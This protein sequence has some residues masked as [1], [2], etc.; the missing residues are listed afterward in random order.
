MVA[1]AAPAFPV[2]FKGNGADDA[3]ANDAAA[4]VSVSIAD[5]TDSNVTTMALDDAP[6]AAVVVTVE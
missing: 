2:V 1:A 6:D 5:E 3:A 4:D